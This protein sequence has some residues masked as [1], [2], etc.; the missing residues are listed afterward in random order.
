MRVTTR[1]APKISNRGPAPAATVTGKSDTSVSP[2]LK[3]NSVRYALTD[4]PLGRTTSAV[5]T[6]QRPV[7]PQY[8]AVAIRS[9]LV[10]TGGCACACPCDCP[11]PELF[12]AHTGE[13]V[14]TPATSTIRNTRLMMVSPRHMRGTNAVYA[15][16]DAARS[17]AVGRGLSGGGFIERY[18]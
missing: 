4:Q 11:C 8:V 10:S 14:T 13:L 6:N 5:G 15:V 1:S 18:T 2:C 12:C 16:A 9:A 3:S 7:S 17:G